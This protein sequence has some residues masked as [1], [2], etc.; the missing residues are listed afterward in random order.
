M[1]SHYNFSEEALGYLKNFRFENFDCPN[2][3]FLN[4]LCFTS[5]SHID[6]IDHITLNTEKEK[7]RLFGLAALIAKFL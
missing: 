1:S 4:N 3:G 7:N 6:T 2:E 5:Y